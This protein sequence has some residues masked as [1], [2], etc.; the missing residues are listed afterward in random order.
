MTNK[1]FYAVLVLAFTLFALQSCDPKTPVRKPVVEATVPSVKVFEI[2]LDVSSALDVSQKTTLDLRDAQ[3]K[4]LYEDCL[5]WDMSDV[6]NSSG[7][8]QAEI[9]SIRLDKMTIECIKPEGVDLT[10]FAPMRLYAGQNYKLI[11]ETNAENAHPNLLDLV[12]HEKD[13]AQYITAD[14]L[15][16]RISTTRDKISE[17][18]YGDTNVYVKITLSITSTVRAK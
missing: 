7:F 5:S 13:L 14:Q 12:L 11:A 6:I 9:K 10:L 1:H 8:S 18:P 2:P 15:P 3:E 16:I 17:W 4:V